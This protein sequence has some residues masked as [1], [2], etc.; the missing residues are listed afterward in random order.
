MRC[1]SN[2]VWTGC[3]S[4]PDESWTGM[5]SAPGR[6]EHR[7]KAALSGL[8]SPWTMKWLGEGLAACKRDRTAVADDG[9]ARPGNGNNGPALGVVMMLSGVKRRC[10]SFRDCHRQSYSFCCQRQNY[11]SWYGLAVRLDEWWCARSTRHHGRAVG[12]WS[13]SWCCSLSWCLLVVESSLYVDVEVVF[14]AKPSQAKVLTGGGDLRE[15][16]VER[17]PVC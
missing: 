2:Y 9:P 12:R 16:Q 4:A 5:R 10:Y 13:L 17:P 8:L 6:V 3:W 14:Q 11:S 7:Q 15:A 1:S